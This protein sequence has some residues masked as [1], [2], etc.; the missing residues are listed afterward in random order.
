M[1]LPPTHP[2]TVGTVTPSGTDCSRRLKKD[3]QGKSQKWAWGTEGISLDSVSRSWPK[4]YVLEPA[5]TSFPRVGALVTGAGDG[6]WAR[7]TPPV[8]YLW[9][10]LW[11]TAARPPPMGNSD[12]TETSVLHFQASS[13]G[14]RTSRE[15]A[16]SSSR[17]KLVCACVLADDRPT[18]HWHAETRHV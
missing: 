12:S 18:T 4:P 13:T 15:R 1:S 6:R 14:A 16:T 17:S 10:S 11:A 3:H 9:C 8:G 7:G 2:D 5:M